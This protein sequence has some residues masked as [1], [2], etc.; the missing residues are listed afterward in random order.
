MIIQHQ[1]SICLCY[2]K[3]E[4][5]KDFKKSTGHVNFFDKLLELFPP[6]I[7]PAKKGEGG[8]RKEGNHFPVWCLV[9]WLPIEHR[10]R[11][12]AANLV[13]DNG[14][15]FNQ[16]SICR[17]QLSLPLLALRKWAALDK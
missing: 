16:M 10:M 13:L 15:E 7:Y 2:Q 6:L 9:T 1:L 5:K 8:G 11:H 14:H 4:G 17:R 12:R 3:T